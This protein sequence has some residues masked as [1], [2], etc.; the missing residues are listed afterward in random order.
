M[1][2]HEEKN[3]RVQLEAMR[4]QLPLELT[5]ELSLPDYRS[6]ISRLLWVRPTV[7]PPERF[8]GGGK[9]D[10]SGCVR[11]CAL[12]TGPD[13]ALYT[14][15]W[16][17]NYAFSVPMDAFAGFDVA[18]GVELQAEVMADALTGRVTGPRKLAVRCRMHATLYG[19]ADKNLCLPEAP[20]SNLCR[21][22]ELQ[23][24]S[25]LHTGTRELLSISED[26]ECEGEVRVIGTHGSVFLPEVS[27]G[28]DEILC[29]GE[30][31]L[32]LLLCKEGENAEKA[33]TVVRHLPFE[34]SVICEGA[35]PDCSARATAT[36][37]EITAAV[38][39]GHI[40]LDAQILLNAEAV[41]QEAV[42]V[43]R[44]AFAPGHKSDCRFSEEALRRITVCQNRH[45]SMNG[46]LPL[47]QLKLPQDARVLDCVADAE[48]R[49]KST[50]GER[51]VLAGELCVHVLYQAGE[52][53]GV[54]DA[55]F[56]WRSVCE[57]SGAEPRADVWVA[58]CRLSKTPDALRVDAELQLSLLAESVSPIS[59]LTEAK[60]DPVEGD[61]APNDPEVYFPTTEETLWDVAKR[62]QRV[63]QALAAANALTAEAPAAPESLAGKKFLLIP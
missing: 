25:R 10:F 5:A 36:V 27:A 1:E 42:L 53:C 11:F 20:E 8:I 61:I 34:Q 30:L 2:Q 35:T 47:S 63:P 43:C 60:F 21:L 29:K 37:G 7:L 44:D 32:T 14:A 46:E 54:C 39:E 41:T 38:E 28:R 23:E 16:E 50:D 4:R 59:V 57:A 18:R 26:A 58:V 17:E 48:L 56:P 40:L 19:Y 22:C 12:Y 52:E 15:E 55:M 31:H 24:C 13:A 6:E 49:E 51:C 45:F 62:Y 3:G 9:A 33:H